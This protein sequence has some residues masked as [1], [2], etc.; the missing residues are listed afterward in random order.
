MPWSRNARLIDDYAGSLA[1]MAPRWTRHLLV[2]VE[3]YILSGGHRR[4]LR[5]PGACGSQGVTVRVL[6][7][8]WASSHCRDYKAT[9]V[10]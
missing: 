2:H 4:L 9:I 5:C 10:D 3:F 8:H 6:L 1:A 7:D